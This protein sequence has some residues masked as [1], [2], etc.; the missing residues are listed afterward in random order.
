MFVSRFWCVRVVFFGVF[1]VLEVY[2]MIVRLL[3]V[4]FGCV[5]G[6]GVVLSREF[7]IMVLWI[8]FVRVV[9]DFCVFVIGS[10][11][12]NWVSVGMVW[13]MLIDMRFVIV[14]LVGKFCMVEM[15]LF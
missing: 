2:W 10:W 9:C 12:V 5:E 14:R 13:V 1:V 6:S 4:G 8:F 11:S 3:V 7:Y 15:I